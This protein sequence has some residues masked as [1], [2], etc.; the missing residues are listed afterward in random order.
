[1]PCEGG[2]WKEITSSLAELGDDGGVPVLPVRFGLG[3]EELLDVVLGD[4]LRNK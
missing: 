2:E 4:H 1:M 3:G